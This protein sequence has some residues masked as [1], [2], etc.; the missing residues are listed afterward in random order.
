MSEAAHILFRHMC[1]YGI[2]PTVNAS[3]VGGPISG[4]GPAWRWFMW[5][6]RC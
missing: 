1:T 2:P 5:R 3:Q 6:L 4:D